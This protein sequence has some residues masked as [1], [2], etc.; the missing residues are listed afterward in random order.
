M[1][2]MPT[3]TEGARRAKK[4]DLANAPSRRLTMI[5]AQ[6]PTQSLA[7]L[8]RPLTAQS[9]TR[10]PCPCACFTLKT[11]ADFGISVQRYNELGR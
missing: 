11:I 3:P 9:F 1:L 8:H 10:L 4:T 2:G 7:A 6:E 5:V